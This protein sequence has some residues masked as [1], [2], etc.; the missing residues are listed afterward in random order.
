ME[1]IVTER[2]M[3]GYK[4][5]DTSQNTSFLLSHNNFVWK[6]HAVLTAVCD[7]RVNCNLRVDCTCGIY[8]AKSLQHLKDIGYYPNCYHEV[9][10]FSVVVKIRLWGVI[11]EHSL[12]WRAQH[13]AIEEL[14][15]CCSDPES[16]EHLERAASYEIFYGVPCTIQVVPIPGESVTFGRAIPTPVTPTKPVPLSFE[17]IVGLVALSEHLTDKEL[18]MIR[19]RLYQLYYQKRKQCEKLS[20]RLKALHQVYQH[21]DAQLAEIKRVFEA[22]KGNPTQL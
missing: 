7:H 6:P 2:G 15:Y 14:Y 17:E 8:A 22:A 10:E 9:N 18:K 4:K 19:H 16:E 13:A 20:L 5:L 12:G 11:H 3:E 21:Y 1:T